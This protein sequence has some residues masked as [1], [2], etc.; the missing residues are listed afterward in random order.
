MRTESLV[1]VTCKI[2]RTS[3]EA[4]RVSAKYCGDDCRN[5]ARRKRYKKDPGLRVAARERWRN[6]SGSERGHTLIRR[7]RVA[8]KKAGLVP[9][10]E[11]PQAD[12][13]PALRALKRLYWRAVDYAGRGEG[14][15]EVLRLSAMVMKEMK[16]WRAIEEPTK[17]QV[18][19]LT[20][21]TDRVSASLDIA[22][23]RAYR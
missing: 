12:L 21:F 9:W 4:G 18:A 1:D 17:L 20:T 8:R 5:E 13:R 19:K 11:K 6:W 3:F 14:S 7:A 23:A 22:I 2:C 16:R 10:Y 15:R